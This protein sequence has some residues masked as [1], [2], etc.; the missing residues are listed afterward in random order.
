MSKTMYERTREPSRGENEDSLRA[1]D[2]KT[3][4]EIEESLEDG[5]SVRRGGILEVEFCLCVARKGYEPRR[6]SNQPTEGHP[7]QNSR[8]SLFAS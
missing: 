6:G 4:I 2:T 3:S 8:S 5:D 1:K 7:K